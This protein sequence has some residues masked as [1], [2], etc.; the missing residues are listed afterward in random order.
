[1]SCPSVSLLGIPVDCGASV[2]GIKK[3]YIA[4]VADVD[5]VT[6][7]VDGEVT[8]ITMA[9]SAKFK[10]FNF[11][12]GN[13]SFTSNGNRDDKNG[14]YF[15]TS[16][17]TAQ[18]NRMEKSKRSEIVALAKADTYVIV[19]DYNDIYWFFGKDSY[20]SLST[21]SGQSGAALADG[22]FYNIVLT[23]ETAELP[24][25]VV[26]SAITETIVDVIV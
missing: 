10:S 24:N 1:M 4:N 5:S 21:G 23:T 12:R 11:R 2:G 6:F 20:C 18:F 16:E 9:A 15:A 17:I 14:T 19:K 7:G 25:T 3:I 13:A 26:S 8:A 22:N